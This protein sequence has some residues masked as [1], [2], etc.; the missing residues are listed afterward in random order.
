VRQKTN[1]SVHTVEMELM[2]RVLV[3]RMVSAQYRTCRTHGRFSFSSV[4]HL[5]TAAFVAAFIFSLQE[6]H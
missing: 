6:P 1:I 3:A 4:S 5:V 2:Y